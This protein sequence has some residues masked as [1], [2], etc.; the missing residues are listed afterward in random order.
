MVSKKQRKIL[1]RT[2]YK[3][4]TR[5]YSQMHLQKFSWA[6]YQELTPQA[7]QSSELIQRHKISKGTL[8][9]QFVD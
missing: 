3:M 6:Q 5:A 1:T 4:P 7:Y 8:F 9:D 2:S